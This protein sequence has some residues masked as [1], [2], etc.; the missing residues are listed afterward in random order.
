MKIQ[1]QKLFN[2]KELVGLK[3]HWK[4][5]NSEELMWPHTMINQSWK[6]CQ[7]CNSRI[8]N[9]ASTI[10]SKE[11]QTAKNYWELKKSKKNQQCQLQNPNENKFTFRTIVSLGLNAARPPGGRRGAPVINCKNDRCSSGVNSPMISRS[12]KH[13][14]DYKRMAPSIHKKVFS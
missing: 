3:T 8:E 14:I 7:Q 12:C 9:L 13:Q 2:M 1:F 11:S 10:V 6:K 4:H 5:G